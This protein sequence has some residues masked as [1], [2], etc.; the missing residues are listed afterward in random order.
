MDPSIVSVG[1]VA[2]PVTKMVPIS[3]KL[4]CSCHNTVK[5]LNTV[6]LEIEHTMNVSGDN[7]RP[8]SCMAASG[9]LGVWISLHNSAV[10]RLF[11]VNTYE[12]LTDINIAPAVTKMLAS[13][14]QISNG[15]KIL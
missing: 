6:S 4:W 12:C 10:L 14:Y 8:V 5:V 1:T 15:Q 13:K 7:A 3:G 2:S 11:H 9:N